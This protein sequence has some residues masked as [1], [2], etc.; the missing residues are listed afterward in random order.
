MLICYMLA[1]GE[2]I[3]RLVHET[4]HFTEGSAEWA[5]VAKYVFGD[6][7]NIRESLKAEI[8]EVIGHGYGVTDADVDAVIEY[9]ES[10][11]L[12]IF[13]SSLTNL[14]CKFADPNR[15]RMTSV[16]ITYPLSTRS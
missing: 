4:T 2:H 6:G 3:K 7:K 8:G 13:S 10:G 15:V 5:E 1:S 14:R 16:T 12:D 9:I 11:Y